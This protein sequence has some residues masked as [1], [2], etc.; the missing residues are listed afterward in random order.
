M[1]RPFDPTR[2][3]LG[4]LARLGMVIDPV[5]TDHRTVARFCDLAGID[6]V[7]IG[8]SDGGPA[9][10]AGTTV[11]VLAS[12]LTRARIGVVLGAGGLPADVGDGIAEYALEASPD[13]VGL[14]AAMR[15]GGT[16]SA[17]L[18]VAIDSIDDARPLLAVAD[19]IVLP[20]WRLPDLETAADEIRAE[21]AEGGRDPASLGVAALLPV[22]VGRTGAEAAARVDMDPA[23]GRL[24]HPREVG[25][26]GT[27][28]ECQDRVIALA[29]A[30]V[31]DLRCVLPVAPDIHDVIAQLTAVAIGTTE[32]LLP[33]SL[34]SPAPPPPE[35]WGGRPDTPPRQGVSGG[36]RRS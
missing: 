19:D 2:P 17:R 13:A 27:L 10:D 12:S 7:W 15:A 4:R 35:G 6:I 18:S 31:T 22:S 32:V 8:A 23:F 16:G 29:H 30:G 21:A 9:P 20:G 25:I 36:S 33:G 1:T 11:E 3:P 5:H 26:F 34:R 24:G 28:E 14:A